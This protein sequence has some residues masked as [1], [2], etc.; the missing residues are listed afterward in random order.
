[1]N[2]PHRRWMLPLVLLLLSG[3]AEVRY[4]LRYGVEETEYEQLPVWPQPPEVPRFIYAGELTGEGNY[5]V[6]ENENRTRA[7]RV[8]AWIVG[9]A[10]P[11]STPRRLQR[12]VHGTVDAD[13][14][15]L[16]TDIAWGAVFVFDQAAGEL[17]IWEEAAIGVPFSSP[18][19]IA[20]GPGSDLL[21][22]DADLAAVFRIGPD[23]A[24]VDR[25]GVGLLQRP[26]GI[27]R[28]PETGLVYVADTHAHD[29]KVFDDEG[30]L[31]DVIGGRGERLG[32][33]NFPTHL[34]WRD[35]KLYVSDTMNTRVQV[36]DAMGDVERSFG[37]R[38]LFVGNLVRPKGVA[39]DSDGNIYIVE[40]YHDHLLVHDREGRFLLPIGGEGGGP[41]QF[42]L[43]GGVWIDGN[44]RVFVADTFNG[45][46][47][48]FQYLGSS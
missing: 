47:S 25:F 41:G 48:I 32:Q 34:A 39:V 19:G 10:K 23:G 20:L 6:V 27:A 22:V 30:L 28:D 38:G 15:V 40:S 16:V 9:L 14:R 37:E 13:G 42:Y 46:V 21:V 5:V 11:E 44:D 26:T 43:P 7:E 35:G 8:L 36:F 12:P 33:F 17:H 24:P 18:V 3:C 4:E 29:I 1:M 2:R 31:V 45:R